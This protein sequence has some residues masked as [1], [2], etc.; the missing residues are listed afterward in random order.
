LSDIES[1]A[2]ETLRAKLTALS[3]EAENNEL[4]VEKT[5]QIL[6][7]VNKLHSGDE[8]LITKSLP[9]GVHETDEEPSGISCIFFIY[10][11]LLL[12]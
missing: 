7:H 10:Y 5:L 8:S 6:D 2:V 9:N 12:I 3:A 1:E 4:Y 11:I